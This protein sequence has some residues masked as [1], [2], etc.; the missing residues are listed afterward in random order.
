[1]GAHLPKLFCFLSS[2]HTCLFESQNPLKRLFQVC[3]VTQPLLHHEDPKLTE[4]V[5]RVFFWSVKSL[6][7]FM[8]TSLLIWYLT[9]NE[10]SRLA[11]DNWE[12]KTTKNRVLSLNKKTRTIRQVSGSISTTLKNIKVHLLKVE[13]N[14]KPAAEWYTVQV[15][16]HQVKCLQLQWYARLPVVPLQSVEWRFDKTTKSKLA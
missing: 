2:F 7:F 9:R 5:S 15:T 1:M 13:E 3:T 16:G 4:Y 12:D 10:D 8:T 14:I 6:Q 11:L